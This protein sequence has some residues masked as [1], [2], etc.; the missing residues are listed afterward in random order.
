MSTR[1][2]PKTLSKTSKRTVVKNAPPQ[3]VKEAAQ[4]AQAAQATQAT[5]A[6]QAQVEQQTTEQVK[7][8]TPVM[9][10]VE[11]MT[12]KFDTLITARMEQLTVAK[13]ELLELKKM[14]KEFLLTVKNLTKKT[15]RKRPLVNEDGTPRK[16][17]GF[18]SPVVVSDLLYK[19]LE[20][21]G[22]QHGQPIART[23]VT[24]F[25]TQYIKD[26]NLQNP[27]HRR[28][29]VPDKDLREIFGEPVEHKD[30]N[31][32]SSPKVWT[33]LRMQKYLSSHFPKK[34]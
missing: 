22:V 33:Y 8:E 28:E 11:N 5:Q 1:A 13:N 9:Q 6:T 32:P 34:Q 21:F 31:D 26:K 10:Q 27:E 3:V 17:S 16:P 4:A 30:P 15:K 25:V 29:I 12:K 24:R 18:A 2:T 19:F 7:E 23:D 20:Q 14:Q